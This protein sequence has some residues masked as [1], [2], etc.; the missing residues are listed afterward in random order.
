MT[1]LKSGRTAHFLKI[2]FLIAACLLLGG[3]GETWED[4]REHA[5]AIHSLSAEFVQEKRISI[6]PEPIESRGLFY[7]KA[8]DSL[9]WEYTAPFSSVLLMHNGDIRRF[10]KTA[11]GYVEDAAAG[12]QAMQVV[13]QEISLWLAGRFDEN[14]DFTADLEPGG[15]I[16][17]TPKTEGLASMIQRIELTLSDRPGLMRAVRIIENAENVTVLT[18]ENAALNPELDEALFTAL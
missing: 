8:P 3:W 4:I 11:D 12:L 7:F 13:F 2:P 16:I 9:R 6:L 1:A 5:G 14:P 10:T 17:L 15:K 18:F